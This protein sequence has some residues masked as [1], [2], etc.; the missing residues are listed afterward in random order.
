MAEPSP[1][2]EAELEFM[3]ESDEGVDESRNF[4][5]EDGLLVA[6]DEVIE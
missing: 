2:D 5:G 6:A 4:V 3:L 1:A